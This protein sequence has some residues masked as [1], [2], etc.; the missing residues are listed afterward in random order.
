M[1]EINKAKGGKQIVVE[2]NPVS[3]WLFSNTMSAWIWLVLRLYLGYS[4]LVAGWGKIT[5]PAW[6]GEQA[7][8]AVKGFMEGALSLVE[9]GDVPT[10]YAWFLEA[11]V[12]PNAVP[13]SYMVA[14]GEVLVGLGLIVG[15]LTGIAAFFG[16]VMNMS[17]LLAG[18]VSTNPIM[19]LIALAL[20]M[21]WKVAGWYGL[22]RWALP[23]L[24][25]PWSVKSKET[26]E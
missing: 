26:T 4:W 22:D 25:T 1:V 21:A 5:D 18:T 15:F 3:R 6:T 2:E 7:G 14:W 20:M 17:F 10:W 13:F 12:I 19:F 9:A 24:G 16:A 8:V 11:V 23:L